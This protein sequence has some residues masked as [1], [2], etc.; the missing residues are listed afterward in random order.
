MMNGLMKS[1]IRLKT[2][3]RRLPLEVV[4][5]VVVATLENE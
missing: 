2:S 4:L 3:N 5:L 1:V